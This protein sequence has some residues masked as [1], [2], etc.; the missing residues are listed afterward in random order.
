MMKHILPYFPEHKVYV[1]TCGGGASDLLAK[2]PSP[3][4][5]YNDLDSALVNFWRVLRD[6]KQFEE[7]Y[8]KVMLTPYSRQEFFECRDTWNDVE[9]PV[10]RAFRWFV[11]ARM[12][13]GGDFAHSFGF[14]RDS[15]RGMN[16]ETSKWLNAIHG[17][18]DVHE[19]LMRVIIENDD[20]KAVIKRYDSPNT[21][22]FV[23]PPYV[24]STRRATKYMVDMG[25]EEHQ[26]L[27][28]QLL[29]VQGKVLLCGYQ[30]PI[31]AP[32]EAANWVRV[33]HQTACFAAGRTRKTGL[34][35]EGAC[36]REQKRTESFWMNYTV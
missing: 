18:P 20:V 25:E 21:F 6:D 35:G 17:L 5:V 7:F 32:L 2:E 27:V 15:R 23:D 14:S 30:N 9:E 11:V 4:E 22:F 12:S 36:S 1:S 33:D 31:Y 24:E 3:S 28:E 13:F 19:R 10:E 16:S 34:L 29:G 8:R 26:E